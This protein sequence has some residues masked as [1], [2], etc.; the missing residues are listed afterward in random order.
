M[1]LFL[2]IC[3]TFRLTLGLDLGL[4]KLSARAAFLFYHFLRKKIN[5]NWL[6]SLPI[7]YN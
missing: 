3:K 1:K 2:Q 7:Q 4:E 6:Y 5:I